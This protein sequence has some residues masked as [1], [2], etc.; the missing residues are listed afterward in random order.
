MPSAINLPYKE[1]LDSK[2]VLSSCETVVS[3]LEG[4]GIDL[5]K[6]VLVY[7]NGGVSACVAAAALESVGHKQWSVYDGSWNEYGNLDGASVISD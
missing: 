2:G 7:C 5:Q 4:A 3:A 6:P 1:F